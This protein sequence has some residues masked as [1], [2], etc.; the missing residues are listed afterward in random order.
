MK[1][2]YTEVVWWHSWLRRWSPNSGVAGSNPTQGVQEIW[3]LC[4]LPVWVC[5]CVNELYLRRNGSSVIVDVPELFKQCI[6]VQ[7]VQCIELCDM[8]YIRIKIS[9]HFISSWAHTMDSLSSWAHTMDS[10]SILFTIIW[11][12]PEWVITHSRFMML[13]YNDSRSDAA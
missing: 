7:T 2:Y 3:I 9:F 1:L 4:H 13:I 8:R 11:S 5:L 12:F 10:L 6:Y